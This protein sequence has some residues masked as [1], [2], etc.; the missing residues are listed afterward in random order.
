MKLALMEPYMAQVC[1]FLIVYTLGLNPL[2]NKS[3][4]KLQFAKSF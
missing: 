4:R 1:H 2:A 3:G